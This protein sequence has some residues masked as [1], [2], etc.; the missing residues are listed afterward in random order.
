MKLRPYDAIQICLLLFFSV[1]LLELLRHSF[2][3]ALLILRVLTAIRGLY[4]HM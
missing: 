3:G 4:A 2:G 1:M